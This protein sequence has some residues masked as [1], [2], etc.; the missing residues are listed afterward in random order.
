MFKRTVGGESSKVHQEPTAAAWKNTILLYLKSKYMPKDIS[1]VKK[2][3][4]LY[5]MLPDWSFTLKGESYK[6]MKLNKKRITALVCANVDGS[7]SFHSLL[8]KSQNN[9]TVA[10][11]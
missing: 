1:N 4:L 9:H 8:H 10:K 3:G 11:T 7:G 5:Y 6:G 2:C